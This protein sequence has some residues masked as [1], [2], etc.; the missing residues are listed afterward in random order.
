MAIEGVL[1]RQKCAD[2]WCATLWDPCLANLVSQNSQI[3][4]LHDFRHSW[5]VTSS[6]NGPW[7]SKL[8][9]GFSS[10]A[11]GCRCGGLRR[12]YILKND[13]P[14]KDVLGNLSILVTMAT[15][16]MPFQLEKLAIRKASKSSNSD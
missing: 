2:K 12:T 13:T 3:F 10:K 7:T 16:S 15:F 6:P 4:N 8:V 14:R 9:F 1:T 11:R 5:K